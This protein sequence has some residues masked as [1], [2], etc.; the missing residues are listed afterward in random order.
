M[1]CSKCSGSLLPEW[2]PYRNCPTCRA[3]DAAQHRSDAGRA[4]D[5]RYR[6]AHGDRLRADRT[7]D[8]SERYR[9]AAKSKRCV[10][11][12]GTS[13]GRFARCASCR[14]KRAEWNRNYRE[15]LRAAE[16]RA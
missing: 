13:V 10:D 14:R 12:C 2:G 5:A 1:T 15:R 4:R 9:E 6:E 3:G 16:A 8:M 11:G 7:A